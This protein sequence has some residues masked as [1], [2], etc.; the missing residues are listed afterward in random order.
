MLYRRSLLLT[1]AIC[2]PS[3]DSVGCFV[4]PSSAKVLSE[5]ACGAPP[6]PRLNP[7]TFRLP[8]A[9]M[10]LPTILMSR[11][12]LPTSMGCC[13]T[14]E[15]VEDSDDTTPLARSC[16]IRSAR[17]YQMVVVLIFGLRCLGGEN[18]DTIVWVQQLDTTCTPG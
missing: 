15:R 18:A 1:K 13:G 5:A 10:V 4:R 3:L 7:V 17:G 11:V 14:P 6:A 8:S 16:D 12:D 9:K 2:D